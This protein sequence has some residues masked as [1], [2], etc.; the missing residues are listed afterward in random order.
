VQREDVAPAPIPTVELRSGDVVPVMGLGTW[1]L[2][3]D[4][5]R[6]GIEIGALRLGLD[7]GMN[8]VDTAEMY[9]N[10]AS[11]Q[12]VGDA[13]ADRR[14]DAY[15]VDKVLPSNAT[16]RGTILA[17][18]RS[19]RQLNTDRVDLYLLHWR[20][21]VPLTETVAG[22]TDLMKAGR[23]R[24]WGVS[25]FDLRDMQELVSLPDG[26]GVVVNQVLYNLTRRGIEWDLL[27]W[28]RRNGIVVM[29]YSPIEQ[30]RLLGHPVLAR[31]AARHEATPAQVA[32]AWLIRQESV[33]AIPRASTPEHVRDNRAA[34]DVRLTEQDLAEIDRAFPPPDG[35]RPLEMI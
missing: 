14:D 3:E 12:L 28:C 1:Y 30:G 4:P 11:E 17:C 25:N 22:F 26:A 6:H 24:S 31:I 18:E 20:G 32:L 2:A 35:P 29:A 33:V 13:L 15:V 19:L 10:G 9:A 5:S 7:L 34:A 16:R 23:I 8:L 21:S 27:P